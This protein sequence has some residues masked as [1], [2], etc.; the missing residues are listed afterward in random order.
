LELER[1]QDDPVQLAANGKIIGSGSLVE[2]E[3]RLGVEIT[4]WGGS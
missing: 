2:I 4:S 1:A 3:G